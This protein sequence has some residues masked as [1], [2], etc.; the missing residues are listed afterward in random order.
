MIYFKTSGGKSKSHYENKNNKKH[1]FGSEK[2]QFSDP[3][4]ASDVT[5]SLPQFHFAKINTNILLV[6]T[7]SLTA[8]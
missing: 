6:F 2:S 8:K 4:P 1:L 7:F 5:S 3:L